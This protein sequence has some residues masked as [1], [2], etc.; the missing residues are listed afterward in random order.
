MYQPVHPTRESNHQV[1]TPNQ[2][3]REEHPK[4]YAV[5][6]QVRQIMDQIAKTMSAVF[7]FTLLS[8]LA[9]LY[10]ALL[11]TQDERIHQAAIMRTLGADSR[12]LRRLHLTEFA[13]LG[14]LSGLFAAAGGTLLGW[15]LAIKVL[16]IP[17][18]SSALIWLVGL[19][20]G[21]VTVTLAGWL[22]TRRVAQMSPLQVLQSV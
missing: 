4:H 20:G 16:E 8:G 3:Y 1:I 19:G 5:I 6:E 13:V 17:Y 22:A 11:A 12:Y 9:V 14:A 10:A 21:I 15:V 2:F 18:H 7:L